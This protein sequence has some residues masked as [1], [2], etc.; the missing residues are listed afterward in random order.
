[1]DTRDT[2]FQNLLFLLSA[3]PIGMGCVITG[4][5]T[6]ETEAATANPATTNDPQTG[7]TGGADT[8]DP[9]ATGGMTGSTGPGVD[10]GSSG[11]GVDSETGVTTG[12][13]ELPPACVTYAEAV[14]L[15]YDEKAGAAAGQYCAETIAYYEMMYGAECVTA[16]EDWLACLSA[17][18][19]EEFTGKDPV[20]EEQSMALGTACGGKGGK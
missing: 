9:P 11:P 2:R 19:C 20:C 7:T 1:M 18:T 3:A 14:T 12:G 15:C 13:T 8:D 6:G 16:F 17:L 10:S 5:D 4:D